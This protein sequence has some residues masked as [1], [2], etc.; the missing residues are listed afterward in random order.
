MGK[1]GGPELNFKRARM[2]LDSLF[3][4][5]SLN[6]EFRFIENF[7]TEASLWI[8]NNLNQSFFKNNFVLFINATILS[9]NKLVNVS[10]ASYMLWLVHWSL[11]IFQALQCA[12]S[13]YK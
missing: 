10:I 7:Y 2:L 13:M 6:K 4:T 3:L 5:I 9:V 8:K 1:D 12:G 11:R